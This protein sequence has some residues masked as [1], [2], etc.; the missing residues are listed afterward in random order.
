MNIA[1]QS[2]SLSALKPVS[3]PNALH[4]LFQGG[5]PSFILICVYGVLHCAVFHCLGNRSLAL[6]C[7]LI[8]YNKNLTLLQ[9]LE[10]HFFILHQYPCVYML[11]SNWC[12]TVTFLILFILQTKWLSVINHVTN[13]QTWALGQCEHEPIVEGERDLEE[14]QWLKPASMAV[15]DLQK[16]VMEPRLLKTFPYYVTCQ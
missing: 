8:V 4:W 12:I 16:T 9:Q 13:R 10:F 2:V 11:W 6:N 3:T 14:K 7:Q 15:K 5:D 1:G